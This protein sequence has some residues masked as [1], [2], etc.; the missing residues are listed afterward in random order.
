MS[1][2]LSIALALGSLGYKQEILA[3]SALQ[4]Q[5]AF[6]AA[7]AGLECALYA[8]EQESDFAYALYAEPIASGGYNQ[9][10]FAIGCGGIAH[11]VTNECYNGTTLNSSGVSCTTNQWVVSW[12]IPLAYTNPVTQ[13]AGTDQQCAVVQI[14][15]PN[16]SG[17]TYIFSQGYSTSC[18]S[19]P[20]YGGTATR[21]A[22]RGLS[23]SYQD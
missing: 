3:S 13:H 6:Y 5:S 12:E 17:T 11:P 2:V 23:A 7:D 9:A 16:G 20:A 21:F 18:E 19:L 14:Y 10:N 1:V 8:D 15:K 22:S 4:S